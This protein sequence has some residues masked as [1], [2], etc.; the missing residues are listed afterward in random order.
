M[1]CSVKNRKKFFCKNVIDVWGFTILYRKPSKMMKFIKSMSTENIKRRWFYRKEFAYTFRKRIKFK[2][3]KE[4]ELDYLLPRILKHYYIVLRPVDFKRHQKIALRK[5][6]L[7]EQNFLNFVEGRLFMLIYRLNFVN[8]LFMI[9]TLL[10]LGLFTINN[11]V[12]YHIHAMANVGDLISVKKEYIDILRNDLILRMQNNVIFWIVP[13]FLMVSF[14]L[15]FAI[16][17]YKPRKK[18]LY[19]PIDVMDVFIG[20]EYYYPRP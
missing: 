13:R 14:K 4:E 9:K 17:V 2:R 11:K 15:M 3:K 18:D 5:G 8:N 10:D 19:F 16:L 20:T 1:I 12:K 6:R 7:F